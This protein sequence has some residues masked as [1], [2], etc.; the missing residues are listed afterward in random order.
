MALCVATVHENGAPETGCAVEAVDCLSRLRVLE[1]SPMT[2]L[3]ERHN[4]GAYPKTL[5]E[6]GPGLDLE[7]VGGAFQPS[8]ETVYPDSGAPTF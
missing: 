7:S 5:F 8:F 3:H 6:D 2:I 1:P 4:I